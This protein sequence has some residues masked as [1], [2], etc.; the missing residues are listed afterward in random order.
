MQ[1]YGSDRLPEIRRRLKTY[2]DEEL[3][4]LERSQGLSHESRFTKDMLQ[5]VWKRS[6]ELG[7]YGINLPTELGG[8]GLSLVDLCILKE[9]LA[10][11]GSVLFPNV[12]GE[13]GGPLRVGH[14]FQHATPEQRERFFLPVIRG[15]KAFCFALTEREAGSDAS[16]IRTIAVRDGGEFVLNGRKHYIT[17]APFADFAL[18]LAV[19]DQ[20]K[21]ARG[22]TA[23]LVETDRPGCRVV[24][25][26]VPISGQHI[27]ADIILT[28][29]RVPQANVL[30]MEG[31]GFELGMARI[32]VNR[33]LHCPTMIGMAEW[34]LQLSI[35]HAKT[36]TQFGSPIAQFQAVQHMLAE[37]ATGIS[38]TLSTAT[39]ADCGEDIRKEAAMCKLFC[40]E[41][42]FR[43]A[44]KAVQIHGASG[45]TRG[46][47]V[48]WGFRMLRIFR[49]GTGTSEIQKNTIARE[50]LKE[51]LASR[52]LPPV[53]AHEL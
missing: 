2:L 53:R 6:S 46:H 14:I 18:V 33:L 16:R 36:R 4:P 3:I 48:E 21:G 37:M 19:S 13:M 27:E 1:M 17:G 8:Q 44:D 9:D 15:E 35:K 26:D 28:E 34:L 42:A 51:I 30:G 22:I 32:N 24:E 45:V 47:P 50:L 23:F 20:E 25:E 10:A 12:L 39:K 49:I 5:S 11:S 29:C 40:S 41:T 43:V 38:M 52:P 31:K 7:F